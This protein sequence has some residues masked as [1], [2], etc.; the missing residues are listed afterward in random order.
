MTGAARAKLKF[1]KN[2]TFISADTFYLACKKRQRERTLS[3]SFDRVLYSFNYRYGLRT[4]R[5]VYSYI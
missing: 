1:C 3:L 4:V 5:D 2:I